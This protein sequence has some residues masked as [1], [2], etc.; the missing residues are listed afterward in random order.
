MHLGVHYSK[1][2]VHVLEVFVYIT[3]FLL[4]SFYNSVVLI[5]GKQISEGNF[6]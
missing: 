2:G 4:Y 6:K 3:Q 1:S 5:W